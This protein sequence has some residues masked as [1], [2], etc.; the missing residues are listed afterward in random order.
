[1]NI[2]NFDAVTFR[3]GEDKASERIA[4]GYETKILACSSAQR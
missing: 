2:E 1:M 4:R 3:L